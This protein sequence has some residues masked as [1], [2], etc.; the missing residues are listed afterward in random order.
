M[1]RQIRTARMARAKS[2]HTYGGTG[3]ILTMLILSDAINI[4]GNA[5]AEHSSTASM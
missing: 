4:K 5:D 2:S 1:G 3:R